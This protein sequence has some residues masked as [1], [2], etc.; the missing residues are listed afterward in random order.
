MPARQG[1]NHHNAKMTD[2]TVRA[3][4]QT[5]ARGGEIVAPDREGNR[6]RVPVTVNSLARKY[7]V[8]HQTMHALLRGDTWKH[9]S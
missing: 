4:R 6:K 5:Y 8:S 3:A 2:A 7:G 9:V 1:K